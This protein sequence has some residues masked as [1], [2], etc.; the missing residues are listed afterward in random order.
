MFIKHRFYEPYH[1]VH[2]LPQSFVDSA[3]RALLYYH[4]LSPSKDYRSSDVQILINN[5]PLSSKART[6]CHMHKIK[7]SFSNAD[8]KAIYDLSTRSAHFSSV[9]TPVLTR[10]SVS[11]KKLNHMQ[12]AETSFEEVEDFP[13]MGRKPIPSVIEELAAPKQYLKRDEQKERK[14]RTK[15]AANYLRNLGKSLKVYYKKCPPPESP[16]PKS[17]DGVTSFESSESETKESKVQT[18]RSSGNLIMRSD[19]LRGLH[20]DI[21]PK[22]KSFFMETSAKVSK[23]KQKRFNVEVKKEAKKTK[24]KHRT[25][26]SISSGLT[27]A[28]KMELLAIGPILN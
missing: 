22:E 17:L 10:V 25:T 7:H 28:E 18:G 26:T 21:V 4:D 14:E 5:P 27:F 9:N 3:R 16:S 2:K 19:K 6:I 8:F 13:S 1:V 24:K 15:K 11:H 23:E 20:K 12:Y